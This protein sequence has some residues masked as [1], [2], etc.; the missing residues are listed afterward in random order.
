[1]PIC[2]QPF[3]IARGRSRRMLLSLHCSRGRSRDLD[4]SF[5]PPPPPPFNASNARQRERIG[6][7]L[8]IFVTFVIIA[9]AKRETFFPSS[10]FFFFVATRRSQ[11]V[12]AQRERG[13]IFAVRKF[14]SWTK[15][16]SGGGATHVSDDERSRLDNFSNYLPRERHAKESKRRTRDT[17]ARNCR[18]L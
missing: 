2:R 6:K 3:P 14:V 9:N 8:E 16:E 1:M 10:S 15:G 12:G 17:H 18:L 4:S 13:L 7:G 5:F 11:L